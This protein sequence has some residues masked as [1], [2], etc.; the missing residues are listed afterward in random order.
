MKFTVFT[1]TYNRASTIH[2]VYDSLCKQTYKNFEWLIIDDGST[3]ETRTI[4][5][6]WI[7]SNQIK[8]RYFYQENTHK[9]Y[10]I[11]KAAKIAEGEFIYILDSDDECVPEALDTFYQTWRNI[12]NKDNFSGVTGLCIDQ[13]GNRNGDNFPSDQ[14]DSNTLEC[15]L[16]YKVK[17]EKTGI[18]RTDILKEFQFGNEYFSNGFIPEG[19]IW[20]SIANRGYKTRYINK[21]LRIY[22]INEGID[23][24]MNNRNFK[25]N[26]FGDMVSNEIMLNS[27]SKY[28]R[29]CPNLILKSIVIYSAAS[30]CQKK[31]ALQ[32]VKQMR[33]WKIKMM[34]ILLFPLSFVYYLKS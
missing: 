18:V 19:V 4:V 15:S 11:L 32:I 14:F 9:F 7:G 5:E 6:N 21:V 26:S 17:G 12:E 8:I 27:A 23:S 20:Y 16:R 29:F 22:Y 2:R 24:I 30:L 25:K 10:T 34:V 31:S 3:D 13:F 33:N 1:P 28:M